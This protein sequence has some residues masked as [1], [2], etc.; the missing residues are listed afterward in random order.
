MSLSSFLFFG[1]DELLPL[2]DLE[3]QFQTIF[4]KCFVFGIDKSR[5]TGKQVNN[6]RLG[7]SWNILIF[8]SRN[9]SHGRGTYVRWE[10]RPLS[11]SQ[12]PGMGI[13]PGALI[14]ANCEGV[15]DLVNSKRS[16]CS[17]GSSTLLRTSVGCFK[18]LGK[19]S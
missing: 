1:M 7:N 12:S 15:L 18:L 16:L 14:A 9:L 19:L 6:K 5:V 3:N 17:S 8:L 4:S 11:P 2:I 13:S 10:E